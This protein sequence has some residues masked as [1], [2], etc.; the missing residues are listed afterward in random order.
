ME[1]IDWKTAPFYA[2]SNDELFDVFALRTAIFIVEQNCP[3]QEIDA[4]DKKALH[5]LGYYNNEIIAVARVLPQNTSYKE[6][7]IGRFAVAKNYRKKGISDVLMQQCFNCV[8]Q[9]FGNLPIRI[10]A[11]QY[12]EKFYA[13]H[14]FVSTEKTYLEDDIPHVEMLF[15]GT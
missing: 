7:A 10:S 12:A 9:H 13:K 4:K 2:L 8:L 3:Y 1:K 11:Q 6:V 15:S 5:V 14:G